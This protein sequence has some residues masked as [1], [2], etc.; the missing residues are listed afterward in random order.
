MSSVTIHALDPELDER[1]KSEARRV[2]MSKNRLVK[3]LLA[4]S[5][6]MRTGAGYADDY[7]EFCGLWTVAERA[8]FDASQG[9]NE[10]VDAE[11][12]R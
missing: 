5:V 12:W 11:E 6:G 7:R 10:S 4:R 3:E 9:G 8:A 1:L 2:H